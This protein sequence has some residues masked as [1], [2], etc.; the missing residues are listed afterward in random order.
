MDTLWQDIRYSLRMLLANPV[1]TIVAIA[2]LSLGIGANT[3][4]FSLMN[5]I[6]LR[7]LPVQHPEE[8]VRLS[9]LAPNDPEREG[10][11]SLA[12]YEEIR[13]DQ[14]V[15][16][17]LFAWSGGGIVNIDANGDKY[18][19]SLSTVTGEYFS[20][21]GIRPALGRLIEPSDVNLDAGFPAPVAVLGY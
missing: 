9:T 4:I 14:Q 7:P 21:L 18:A 19:G 20:T 2:S 5:A 8:L 16:S 6:I 15:L 13:K 1:T 3:A 10:P 12:A 11:L 17:G